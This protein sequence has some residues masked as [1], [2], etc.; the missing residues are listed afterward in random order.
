MAR[1][2]DT[3]RG[4]APRAAFVA[5]GKAFADALVAG[6]PSALYEA[7]ILLSDG[8]TLPT[9][10]KNYLDAMPSDAQI[11]AI[12]GSGAQSVVADPRT[13]VVGGATRYDVAG[14]VASRFFTSTWYAGIADGRNWPDAVAGG[15]LMATFGEPILLTN[16]SATLPAGTSSF[17]LRSRASAD[18]VFAFGGQASVPTS[19]F[20]AALKA[21][22]DQTTY[23]GVDTQP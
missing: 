13:E 5:S 18:V 21:A 17:L 12:G 3:L 15:T 19:A 23:Y 6:P 7:P 9:V 20:T 11:F 10:T 2:L 22:G 8:P 14:N 4:T 1:K 16:G